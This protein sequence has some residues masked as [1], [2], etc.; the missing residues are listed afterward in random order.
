MV[1][2]KLLK[3]NIKELWYPHSEHP[4]YTYF[5]YCLTIQVILFPFCEFV[6]RA[7]TERSCFI[8]DIEITLEQSKC[9]AFSDLKKIVCT[10]FY[11][12]NI[13]Y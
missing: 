5:C 1:E 7:K 9:S 2:T 6:F 8:F 3:N 13:I 11:Y 12:L 10:L 4:I